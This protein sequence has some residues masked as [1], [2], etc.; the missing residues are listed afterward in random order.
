MFKL[1]KLKSKLIG[2]SF[3]LPG[4]IALGSG[5]GASNQNKQQHSHKL[6]LHD[7]EDNSVGPK[8]ITSE[9]WFYPVVGSGAGLIAVSLILGLGIGI[10]IAKKKERMML[11][12]REEHQKMVESLGMIEQQNQAQTTEE[13]QETDQAQ[14]NQENLALQASAQPGVI[15]Q[16][17]MGMGQPNPGMMNPNMQAQG[18]NPNMGFANNQMG[19][20]PGFNP[21]NG[22]R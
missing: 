12:E 10:P 8:N 1:K 14:P 7:G 13:V 2:L 18:N 22:P 21:Q 5:F 4:A 20:R 9:A 16:P 19:P 3:V 15:N 11:Q 6:V 17:N